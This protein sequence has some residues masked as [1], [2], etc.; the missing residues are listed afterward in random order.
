MLRAQWV[1]HS[2]SEEVLRQLWALWGGG[3]WGIVCDCSLS[4]KHDSELKSC[5]KH[6]V[7]ASD[8][9]T[10]S[11]AT[12][13]KVTPTLA[14][15]CSSKVCVF[16]H[17]HSFITGPRGAEHDL[18]SIRMLYD[19]TRSH[20]APPQDTKPT[21]PSITVLSMPLSGSTSCPRLSPE[22]TTSAQ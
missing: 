3:V 2:P 16:F 4:L 6:T 22:I 19:S 7:T 17:I 13:C 11:Q 8:T 12:S 21:S 5:S 14:H 15:S 18:F 20:R 10:H 1:K 9:H